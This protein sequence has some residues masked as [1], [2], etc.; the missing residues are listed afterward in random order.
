MLIPC[1]VPEKQKAVDLC[2]A[3]V[4][5]APK[6]ANGYVFYG[7]KDSNK[8]AWYRARRTGAD[9]FYIDNS[10]FDSVRGQQFR[11]TKG[12]LQVKNVKARW[13]DGK[14]FDNLGLTIKPWREDP[15][16]YW[17][18]VEQ[19]PVF[20]RLTAMWPTW[21][22]DTLHELTEVSRHPTLIRRWSRD[23]LK[24]Q[25]SLVEDLE[26][27]YRLVTHSSAAAVTALLEGVPVRVR[28][29]SA[30]FG[31]GHERKHLMN[32][33]ADNQF[34]LSELKDGTAWAMLNR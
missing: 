16:G 17:L 20:M 7:V 2:N 23:K 3:F 31:A 25:G 30:V 21:L 15:D 1:P 12:D 5:G 8:D 33:L 13:S 14:R 24:V 22:D 6:D 18:V 4:A 32:V 26:G 10:Y 9:I 28:P 19:S 29:M 27:A 11:V 34:S